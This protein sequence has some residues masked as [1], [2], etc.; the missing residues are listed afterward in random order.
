VTRRNFDV[1]FATCAKYPQGDPETCGLAAFLNENGIA[2]EVRPWNA[3]VDWADSR[4]CIIRSAWDYHRH[5]D[6]F[7]AWTEH[8]AARTSLWNPAALVRWNAHKGY[9]LDLA[10]Q[11]IPIVPTEL[12]TRG[13]GAAVWSVL[14]KHGWTDIVIKPAVSLDGEGAQRVLLESGLPNRDLSH[15]VGRTDFLVQ[16]WV[17]S[18]AAEGEI[19]AVFLDGKFLHAVRKRVAANEFRVQTR[20]GGR[21]DATIIEPEFRALASRIVNVIP[22]PAL[23]ARVDMVRWQGRPCLSELELIEPSL[24]LQAAPEAARI[25]VLDAIRNRLKEA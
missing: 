9:L 13:D 18:V 2:T 17:E 11:G 12:F 15:L 16:P 20:Y 23:Y 4:L 7:L 3:R 19:S 14:A 24:Y 25:A 1:R 8:V 10:T 5:L 22:E 6:R 21:T